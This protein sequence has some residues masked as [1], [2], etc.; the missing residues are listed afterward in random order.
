MTYWRLY[1]IGRE[2]V[3]IN[4]RTSSRDKYNSNIEVASLHQPQHNCINDNEKL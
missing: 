1:V 3:D 4:F 2:Y